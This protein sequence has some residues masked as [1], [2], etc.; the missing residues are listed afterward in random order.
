MSRQIRE[1]LRTKTAYHARQ[2]GPR[3]PRPVCG[4]HFR[5]VNDGW[6]PGRACRGRY[7][8][9]SAPRDPLLTVMNGSFLA[10][11]NRYTYSWCT[12]TPGGS[13][14]AFARNARLEK[15][16]SRN[17]RIF[18]VRVAPFGNWRGARALSGMVRSLPTRERT[19]LPPTA[20]P[21]LRGQES[22]LKS[23]RLIP[24]V[25]VHVNPLE[26]AR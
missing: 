18:P 19:L 2:S 22:L 21:L 6:W 23:D 26:L 25:H 7:C 1:F 13:H 4:N 3:R 10:V 24:V 11:Q 9:P 14:S 16:N 15:M 5:T 12:E 8:R 17:C 20:V